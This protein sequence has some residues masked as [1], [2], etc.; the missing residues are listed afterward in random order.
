MNALYKLIVNERKKNE[1]TQYMR[2]SRQ[3]MK[4]SKVSLWLSE[5]KA[6]AFAAAEMRTM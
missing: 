2:I 1:T 3:I 6:L 5:K 4:R